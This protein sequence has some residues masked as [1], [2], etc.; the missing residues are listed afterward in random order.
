MSKIRLWITVIVLAMLSLPALAQPSAEI[1]NFQIRFDELVHL[2][3]QIRGPLLAI[4]GVE[5]IGIRLNSNNKPA[6]R[7][8]LDKR[9]IEPESASAI[10]ASIPGGGG[11]D[12]IQWVTE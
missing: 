5:G 7:L 4:P 8:Y 6:L 9:V 1:M 10:L 12:A 3:D 11:V 2:I